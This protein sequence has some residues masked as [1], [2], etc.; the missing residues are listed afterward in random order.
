MLLLPYY[1]YDIMS[2]VRVI[3]RDIVNE[4]VTVH[5]I[6]CSIYPGFYSFESEKHTRSLK[7]MHF[8]ISIT[9][10]Q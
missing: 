2:L 3:S 6:D 5:E 10:I 8:R 1:V 7:R 4:K 9:I